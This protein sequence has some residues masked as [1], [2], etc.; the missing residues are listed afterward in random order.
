MLLIL[1]YEI[2][3]R[4]SL[5][6]FLSERNR[7]LGVRSSREMHPSLKYIS[8]KYITF[9]VI[10]LREEFASLTTLVSRYLSNT[11]RK[12]AGVMAGNLPDFRKGRKSPCL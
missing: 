6:H 5:P 7:L 12:S 1:K 2:K 9:K 3:L 4:G 11:R 8:H 10:A